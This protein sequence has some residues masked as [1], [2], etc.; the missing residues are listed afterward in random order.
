VA[1][2]LLALERRDL[3][4]RPPVGTITVGS[5]RNVR[6]PTLPPSPRLRG[7]RL[8][9]ADSAQGDAAH[10]A[11]GGPRDAAE[12][13]NGSAMSGHVG[14]ARIWATRC[15]AGSGRAVMRRGG[16]SLG[17]PA[18]PGVHARPRGPARGA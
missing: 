7:R 1:F 10:C 6:S 18:P 2:D 8:R 11:V 9:G 4:D 14:G 13:E 15:V 3:R 17:T 5:G 12:V 16:R